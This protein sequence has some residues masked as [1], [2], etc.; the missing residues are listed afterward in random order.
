MAV[1]REMSLA[2]CVAAIALATPVAFSADAPAITT[3]PQNQTTVVGGYVSLQSGTSASNAAFR[4]QKNGVDLQ[5]DGRIRGVFGRGLDIDVGDALASD[6]G[7]YRVIVSANGLS[8]T[9]QVAHV[10][11]NATTP[12]KP[13]FTQVLP[14]QQQ[15]GGGTAFFRAYFTTSPGTR[16]QWYKDGQPATGVGNSGKVFL[17]ATGDG[18]VDFA[19]GPLTD[20]DFGTYYLELSNDAGTTRSAEAHVTKGG[21]TAPSIFR[22]PKPASVAAGGSFTLDA[23]VNIGNPQAKFYWYKDGVFLTQTLVEFLTTSY[24]KGTDSGSYYVVASNS[25]GTATSS[26]VAVQVTGDNTSG[27]VALTPAGCLGG[28]A[29]YRGARLRVEVFGDQFGEIVGSYKISFGSS[30]NTYS[31]EGGGYLPAQSGTWTLSTGTDIY[32]GPVPKVTLSGFK[33]PDN[34]TTTAEYLWFCD[35]NDVNV[36]AST[37]NGSHFAHYFLEQGGINSSAAPTVVTAP[38]GGG[39]FPGETFQIGVLPSGGQP[40]AYQWTKDGVNI[41]GATNQWLRFN[42]FSASDAA[43]YTV[44]LSN[45]N[46]TGESAGA[47]LSLTVGTPPRIDVQPADVAVLEGNFFTLTVAAF[48]GSNGAIGYQW[49]K[50]GSAIPGATNSN[51]TVQ[52]ATG[53][54]TGAYQCTVY[55]SGTNAVTRVAQVRVA[56]T[57][58]VPVFSSTPASTKLGAGSGVTLAGVILGLQPTTFQWMKGGI[59]IAGATSHVLNIASFSAADAGDY[60]LVATNPNGSTSTPAATLTLAVPCTIPSSSSLFL[61]KTLHLLNSSGQTPWPSGD[62]M[63]TFGATGNNYTVSESDGVPASSGTWSFTSPTL[64]LNNFTLQNGTKRVVNF[65][66]STSGFDCNYFSYASGVPGIVAPAPSGGFIL[67]APVTPTGPTITQQPQSVTVNEGD[68]ATFTVVATGPDPITYQW[69]RNGATIVGATSPTLT[70]QTGT[71]SVTGDKFTVVVTAGGVAVTSNEAT[72]T[73]TPKPGP[74]IVTQPQSTTIAAGSFATLSVTV[75]GSP[76][77]FFYQW[78]KD[79]AALPG[80]TYSTL[81]LNGVAASAGS[82]TVVVRDLQ[83]RTTT[84]SAAV[85]TINATVNPPVI[86]T[87]PVGGSAAVGH[88]FTLVVSV[89]GTAPFT[90]QWKKNGDILVG[91]TFDTLILNPLALSDAGSYTVDVSNSAG[92]A[93]SHAAVLTVTGGESC[94][95]EAS[96]RGKTMLLVA[97]GGSAPFPASGESV[98]T[99]GATGNTYTVAAGGALSPASGSWTFDANGG[100][101]NVVTLNQFLSGTTAVNLALSCPNGFEMYVTGQSGTHNGTWATQTT[102]AAT[103]PS[104]TVQPVSQTLTAGGSVT[105]SVAAT[106]TAPLGYQ[107]RKDGVAISGATGNTLTLTGLLATDAGVYSAVVS[108][109]A[110]SATSSSALLT[111]NAATDRT[112][113]VGSPSAT[114]NGQVVAPVTFSAVGNE[115]AINVVIQ[116]DTNVVT[117]PRVVL[118]T[119][120]PPAGLTAISGGGRHGAGLS[121][122]Y[123]ATL[124]VVTTNAGT[125]SINVRLPAGETLPAGPSQLLSVIFQPVSGVT[126]Q[127]ASAQAGLSVA[128]VSAQTTDGTALGAAGTVLPGVAPAAVS[129]VANNQTGLFTQTVS[130]SNPSAVDMVGVWVVVKNLNTDPTRLKIDLWNR[131]GMTTNSDPYVVLNRVAAGQS[132]NVTLEYYVRDRAKGGPSPTIQLVVTGIPQAGIAGTVQVAVSRLL[133]TNGTF[134]V[135]FG[136]Q[137][138]LNYYVQYAPEATSTNWETSYPAVL[139]TGRQVQ[140]TDSGPPRTTSIPSSGTNRFYRVYQY[141]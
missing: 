19:P 6:A 141:P 74:V 55:A 27:E 126:A 28:A 8:S 65:F 22:Q 51:Y 115:N 75:Q 14:D 7:D 13:V 63:V 5:N 46:G 121:S 106:G 118:G 2:F 97:T 78:S 15:P 52:P 105:F 35:N 135:S 64:V 92:S 77:S 124:N 38:T 79:G 10:V 91:K 29:D 68:M 43:V 85:V 117:N 128:S 80:E 86:A 73:V 67:D 134:Y 83:G 89:S 39:H 112:L 23:G 96:L 123:D 104:I 132:V 82:Y 26:T 130:V 42:A 99:F 57:T 100:S 122:I 101:L 59:A 98:I 114:D 81:N 49:S 53:A 56:T 127:A 21:G 17:L 11:V 84:S 109:A 107:W 113:A 33:G 136:T 70:S 120:P 88:A 50:D 140:W 139:G 48:T 72:L 62:I 129:S 71:Q 30:G 31:I 116:F 32:G 111:V 47:T 108:N 12:V 18:R 37:G 20:A 137:A 110:G 131:S 58:S 125:V 24:A 69:K 133:Y 34:A 4:W 60:V 66:F 25:V 1:F 40:I 54:A 16:F 102:P 94:V 87:Q 45:A 61:G 9:S 44:K 41:D 90:Y 93:T 119:N 95:S 3:Q 36:F 138:G 103:A 76:L